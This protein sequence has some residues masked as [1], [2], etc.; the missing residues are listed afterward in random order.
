MR[1]CATFVLL[2]CCGGTGFA[3][4][5]AD[6]P[7]D[8]VQEATDH[9][10][11]VEAQADE[12]VAVDAA[13]VDVVEVAGDAI[14]GIFNAI[15]NGFAPQRAV[16]R[17]VD[18]AILNQNVDEIESNVE[19]MRLLGKLKQHQQ[20]QHVAGQVGQQMDLAR[21]GE[22]RLIH[23]VAHLKL[24]EFRRIQEQSKQ[25]ATRAQI[26]VFQ[27]YIK[28]VQ[29]AGDT[30]SFDIQATLEDY[31]LKLVE[32]ELDEQRFQAYRHQVRKRQA[33][34]REAL[35]DAMTAA[36][37]TEILMTADQRDKIRT[38]FL[39]NW[40]SR[41]SACIVYLQNYGL[42]YFPDI[43]KMKIRDVLSEKQRE[44]FRTL[45]WQP[46]NRVFNLNNNFIGLG[47][48]GVPVDLEKELEF[49]PEDEDPPG[50]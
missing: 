45:T 3:Q 21:N 5:L 39:E 8:E 10:D 16:V 6:F 13:A 28:A 29:Y 32:Q 7:V 12:A 26:R 38:I 31:L 22:L 40:S 35:A 33:F 47:N 11:A 15:A 1:C 41:W 17:A 34:R 50:E 18:N 44:A 37:E 9:A 14:G 30:S 46:Q 20:L 24:S 42:R 43:P 49:A 36:L 19:L 48:P 4:A 2:L 25:A 27:Q 23:L